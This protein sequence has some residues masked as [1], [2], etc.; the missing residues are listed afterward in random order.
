[1]VL[2]DGG[3]K[4]TVSRVADSPT[5]HA[6]VYWPSMQAASVQAYLAATVALRHKSFRRLYAAHWVR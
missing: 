3:E 5:R 6:G 4:T 2:T 1:M